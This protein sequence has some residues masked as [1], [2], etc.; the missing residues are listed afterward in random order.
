MDAPAPATDTL[1]AAP[2]NDA[3]G[4]D[5]IVPTDVDVEVTLTDILE[6]VNA[7]ARSNGYAPIGRA[8]ADGRDPDWIFPGTTLIMPDRSLHDVAPGDTMWGIADRFLQAHGRE[9]GAALV[10]L[11]RRIEEGERPMDELRQM[12]E[13]AYL[14]STRRRARQLIDQLGGERS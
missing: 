10:L 1:N 13:N 7:I 14:R 9:N 11:E 4:N 6:M 12:M 8:V 3:P 2:T 5:A